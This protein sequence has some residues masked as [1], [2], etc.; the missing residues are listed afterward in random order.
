MKLL[1]FFRREKPWNEFN[2]TQ[3]DLPCWQTISGIPIIFELRKKSGEVVKA[4]FHGTRDS[5][6][7]LNEGGCPIVPLNEIAA[8]RW[9]KESSDRI[10]R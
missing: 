7:R 1:Q 4:T 8:W 9:S 6:F 5:I 2:G 3:E 10:D